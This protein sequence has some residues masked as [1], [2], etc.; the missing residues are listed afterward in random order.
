MV[1]PPVRSVQM[2][3]LQ[4]KDTIIIEHEAV[5]QQSTATHER[6][7]GA[8]DRALQEDATARSSRHQ[9]LEDLNRVLS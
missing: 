3:S 2:R 6:Q 5:L 1:T 9:F 4:P 8:H 7:R